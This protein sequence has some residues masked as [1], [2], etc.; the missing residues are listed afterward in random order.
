VWEEPRCTADASR[1][2]GIS[3][4]RCCCKK[5]AERRPAGIQNRLARDFNASG[6]NTKWAIDTYFETAEGWLYLGA[7]LDLYS[8]I[9]VGW[10]MKRRQFTSGEY[11]RLLQGHYLVH[12]MSAKGGCAESAA[13]VS[14]F[15]MLKRELINRR[16]TK[17]APM[18]SN[19]RAV[20]QPE[21]QAAAGQPLNRRN[22][23]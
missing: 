9:I 5:A 12:S 18:S 15:E 20:S 2:Q 19:T 14:F 1:R 3:Q 21:A 23:S 16:I 22:Y 13:M 17:P 7:V 10:S 4:K 8:D 11:Q 6:P